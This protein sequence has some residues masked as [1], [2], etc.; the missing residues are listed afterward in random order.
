MASVTNLFAANPQRN[1]NRAAR[2]RMLLS[3]VVVLALLF[4][5]SGVLTSP[6]PAQA[7]ESGLG[8]APSSP[9]EWDC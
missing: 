1:A 4:S 8:S 2:V 3:A 7:T 9:S 5:I 6:A